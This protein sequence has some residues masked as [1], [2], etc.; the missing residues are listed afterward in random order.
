MVFAQVGSP[1]P[2]TAGSAADE[3]DERESADDE[4]THSPGQL[5]LLG[6]VLDH[7]LDGLYGL[8]G[9]IFE[10]IPH[11]AHGTVGLD[12]GDLQQV[13]QQRE[14]INSLDPRLGVFRALRVEQ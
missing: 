8:A 14:D 9:W 3:E 4:D 2:D 12:G 11:G 7:L 13:S 10:E 1:P 5:V 6:V